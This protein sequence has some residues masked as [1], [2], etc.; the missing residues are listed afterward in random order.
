MKFFSLKL[1][2]VQDIFSFSFVCF[3]NSISTEMRLRL[4][5][6]NLWE[7]FCLKINENCELS[8]VSIIFI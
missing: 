8:I 6:R 7:L 5:K 1:S 3:L 2:R 4:L